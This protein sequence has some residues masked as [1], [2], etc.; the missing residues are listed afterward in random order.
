MAPLAVIGLNILAGDAPKMAFI[1]RDYS[2]DAL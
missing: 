1:Q 2:S